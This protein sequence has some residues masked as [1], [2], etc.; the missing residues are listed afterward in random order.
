SVSGAFTNSD[1]PKHSDFEIRP[2]YGEEISVCELAALL[3]GAKGEMLYRN[4]GRLIEVIAR[5]ES[6]HGNV[7]VVTGWKL[8]SG[9][10]HRVEAS[11]FFNHIAPHRNAG[12]KTLHMSRVM[13]RGQHPF[14]STNRVWNKARGPVV[15]A[16]SDATKSNRHLGV[17]GED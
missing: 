3:P 2:A 8:G 17:C 14:A 7:T 15:L 6:T 10:E 1:E 4:P 9:A 12:S 16:G 13:Y 11:D 5:K